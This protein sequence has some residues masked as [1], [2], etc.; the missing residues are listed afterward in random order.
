MAKQIFH[1][2]LGIFPNEIKVP[3]LLQFMQDYFQEYLLHY[4]LRDKRQTE[5]LS[6]VG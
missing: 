6:R 5:V 4:C 1:T 2:I 3:V